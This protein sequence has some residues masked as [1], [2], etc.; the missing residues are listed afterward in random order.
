MRGENVVLSRKGRSAQ[1]PIAKLSKADQSYVK[2][3]Q[4]NP[5]PVASVSV[6]VWEQ[7]GSGKTDVRDSDGGFK[8]PKNI[9]LLKETTTTTKERHYQ[10]QL[11]NRS[12]HDAKNLH[13]SYIIYLINEQN[14]V[15]PYHRSQTVEEIASK[16]AKKIHTEGV[17]FVR[18][19]TKSMT[20][21]S[22]P[23]GNLSIGSTTKRSK[24]RLGWI[25]VRLYETDGSLVGETKSLVSDLRN[26][27][28]VWTGS[29]KKE[30]FLDLPIPADFDLLEKVLKGL[31][32]IK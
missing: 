9:P 21:G 17:S 31:E 29:E 28:M 19:K 7:G 24:E 22:N 25:W 32:T 27:K 16:Q 6:Q 10:I 14:K 26:Q 12:S 23:L 11:S 5:P 1:W 2:K 4:K 18:N 13:L 3:W 20:L 15:V 8:A 30:G